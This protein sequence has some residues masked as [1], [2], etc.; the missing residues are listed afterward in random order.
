VRGCYAYKKGERAEDLAGHLAEVAECCAGLRL[1]D[2]V[3][4]K[5]AREY[6]KPKGYIRDLIVASCLLHDIGKTDKIYQERCDKE[7]EEF[8]G[9]DVKG[10]KLVATA[11]QRPDWEVGDEV[12]RTT[13][14]VPIL[15]HHYFQR[16]LE[17]LRDDLSSVTD[18]RIW[19]PCAEDLQAMLRGKIDLFETREA[20][21][22]VGGVANL[23]GRGDIV[24][25]A[26]NAS[27]LLGEMQGY[28]DAF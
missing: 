17:R 2:P 22:L 28:T 1:L 13:L 12:L 8:S 15:G 10:Y 24:L 18:I 26:T 6:N 25:A 4:F 7:C 23:I 20:R 11:I 19:P 16:E 3:A 21:N 14:L 27:G 9:H 5:I